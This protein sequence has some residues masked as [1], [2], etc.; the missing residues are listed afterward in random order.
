M[1]NICEVF[2]TIQ[3]EASL[4]GTPSIFLRTQGC[5]VGCPFCDTKYSWA[6]EAQ[7]DVGIEEAWQTLIGSPV[8]SRSSGIRVDGIKLLSKIK[9]WKPGIRHIVITG[10][11]PMAQPDEVRKFVVEA[12]AEGYSVQIETSGTYP[13]NVPLAWITV[14]PKIGM[15]GGRAIVKQAI[16]R[17]DE[18][19]MPV[20]KPGD[21][22]KLLN[23]INDHCLDPREL[24]I[25]LQ[26]ISQGKNATQL[27]IDTCFEYGFR[28]S[29]Q[30]HKY[31]GLD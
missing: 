27:C 12:Y 9:A 18:I 31:L 23:F 21:V 28:I 24:P 30:T 10:G 8:G 19:K 26:P 11:E 14:S 1:L 5:D 4:T 6:F 29:I 15:P 13:I 22:E 25:W 2:A 20:G 16:L 3:G 7:H 17:A